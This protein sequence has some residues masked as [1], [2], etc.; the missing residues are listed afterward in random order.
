MSPA[1]RISLISALTLLL[2]CNSESKC[3][4]ENAQLSETGLVVEHTCSDLNITLIPEVKLAETW[5]SGSCS[6]TDDVLTC[7][8]PDQGILSATVDDGNAKLTFQPSK[9]IEVAGL[10]WFGEGSIPR[11]DT[12]L[13]NGF[14]SWS[15]SGLVS[16]GGA[17]G[18]NQLMK[19]LNAQGDE[20]VLREGRELSWWYSYAGSQNGP[21][22]MAGVTEVNTWHSWVR[23]YNHPENA[24]QVQI[25][26]TCGGNGETISVAMATRFPRKP[27]TSRA[28]TTFTACSAPTPATSP[29][30][31]LSFPLLPT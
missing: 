22:L 28:E 27:G 4:I 14:Q 3:N 20:E 9:N 7:H 10:R 12:V 8:I 2:G 24:G 18:D 19:A 25:E 31:G 29:P 1:L 15:H 23:I 13:S 30:A 17:I 5:L 16:M 11:A 21:S 6:L 26:L